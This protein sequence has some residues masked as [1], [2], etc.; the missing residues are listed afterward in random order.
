MKVPF[1]NGI[2]NEVTGYLDLKELF[3]E[4]D[5]DMDGNLAMADG[6]V[7]E[8]EHDSEMTDKQMIT[9]ILTKLI[10]K[11]NFNVR[12]AREALIKFFNDKVD[13]QNQNE[14]FKVV[15]KIAYTQQ[16]YEQIDDACAKM[17]I[18][19]RYMDDE[20]KIFNY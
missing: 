15:E 5:K 18:L 13:N 16:G 8:N 7:N 19:K 6:Q 11:T 10:S 12:D 1:T 14:M 3:N 17:A 20:I 9:E 2:N 4:I